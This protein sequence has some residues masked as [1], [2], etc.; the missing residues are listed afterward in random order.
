MKIVQEG[1]ANASLLS[2]RLDNEQLVSLIALFI[3]GFP[4]VSVDYLNPVVVYADNDKRGV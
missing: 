2:S 3:S 4:E 1:L